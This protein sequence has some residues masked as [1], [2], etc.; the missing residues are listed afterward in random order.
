MANIVRVRLKD[1]SD[2]VLHPETEWSL[3]QDRPSIKKTNTEETWSANTLHLTAEDNINMSTSS[4]DGRLSIWA[5]NIAITQDPQEGTMNLGDTQG[6]AGIKIDSH[7]REIRLAAESL[8]IQDS[9][10]NGG[11]VDLR[12]YPINYGAL[13]NTPGMESPMFGYR[14]T[15]N[16]YDPAIVVYHNH[17][18]SYYY[19]NGSS[20]VSLDSSSF[21]K[22]I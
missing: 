12:N 13:K 7:E 4:Q 15:P 17:A 1:A 16:G 11:F 14:E 20:W 6:A 5:M 3:V 2:N 21:H 19:F 8:K 18:A 10:T 22:I 9:N